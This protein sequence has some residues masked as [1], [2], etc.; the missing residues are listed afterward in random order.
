MDK[1]LFAPNLTF[2][3]YNG[4]INYN[5]ISE[6]ISWLSENSIN[7]LFMT[8]TYGLGP[9]LSVDESLRIYEIAN[10]HKNLINIAQI[11]KASTLKTLELIKCSNEVGVYNFAS[12]VPYYY[13]YSDIEIIDYFK[14][15]KKH[16]NGNIFLYNNPKTTKFNISVSLLN[17][18]I[19]NNIDGIKDSSL[20][21]QIISA[22]LHEKSNNE[23][24]KVM[25]GS[26]IGWNLF[27]KDN[28]DA[29][30][31]GMCNYIPELTAKVFKLSIQND[32]EFNY[33]YRVMYNLY[34]QLSKYDSVALSYAALKTRTNKEHHIRA[35]KQIGIND[36]DLAYI[37]DV[38]TN[39]YKE[40]NI[41]D[42]FKL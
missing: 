23:K 29:M 1:K 12:V 21:C 33:A 36:S 19:K 2:F 16:I 31:S 32:D 10:K 35:P 17:N 28:I 26:S 15:L 24:F 27:R 18:L 4:S 42:Y 14:E 39:A 11:S 22:A 3:N 8:G 41:Y 38:I 6:H 7:G 5:M 37:R 40:L 9:L 34:I 20:N 30:I 25:V 13:N